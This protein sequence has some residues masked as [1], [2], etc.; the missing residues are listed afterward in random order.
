[1]KKAILAVPALAL[2]F[3]CETVEDRGTGEVAGTA[4]GGAAGGLLGSAIADENKAV[5]TLLG[6]AAGAF[7]GNRVGRYL[8]ER[9]K[10]QVAQSTVDAAQTG[11]LQTWRNPESGRSGRARV[12]DRSPQGYEGE[13]R[14]VEQ[15]VILPDGE[16]RADTV[17]ACRRAEGWVVV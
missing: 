9:E 10:E 12:V 6:V 16:E 3:G 17:I 2:C 7:V 13:C 14:E 4:A 11:D 1:M 5:W 15:T 8:D